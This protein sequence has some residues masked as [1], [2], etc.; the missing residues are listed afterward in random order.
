MSFSVLILFSAFFLIFL[1]PINDAHHFVGMCFFFGPF[2]C[3]RVAIRP[4][5]LVVFGDGDSGG[6]ETMR[7]MLFEFVMLLFLWAQKTI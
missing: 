7:F 5:D 4:F 1:C 2:S 3:C 6:V